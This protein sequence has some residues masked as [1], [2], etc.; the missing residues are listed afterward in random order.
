MIQNIRTSGLA[1]VCCD[2]DCDNQEYDGDQTE[3]TLLTSGA[4]RVCF[5]LP[6]QVCAL[7]DSDVGWLNILLDRVDPLALLVHHRRQVLEDGVHVDD[8]GLKQEGRSDIMSI[9]IIPR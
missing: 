5:S 3:D 4:I 2:D 1:D 7:V 8:V 6:E 9:T